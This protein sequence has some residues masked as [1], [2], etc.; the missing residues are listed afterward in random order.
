VRRRIRHRW[1]LR[2]WMQ[3]V[4]LSIAFETQKHKMAPSTTLPI[5][6]KSGNRNDNEYTSNV[7]DIHP[8]YDFFEMNHPAEM[9]YRNDRNG[10]RSYW[11][12]SSHQPMTQDTLTDGAKLHNTE[13]TTTAEVKGDALGSGVAKEQDTSEESMTMQP[14]WPPRQEHESHPE[15][16]SS[17]SSMADI[18]EVLARV[19]SITDAMKEYT[20]KI[21]EQDLHHF[22]RETNSI[23]AQYY[24]C[25]DSQM[26]ETNRLA[27]MGPR[28]QTACDQMLGNY[29]NRTDNSYSAKHLR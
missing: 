26:N 17:L 19:N 14:L 5:A 7:K 18:E 10:N 2:V 23:Q 27:Q 4:N 13:E 8:T 11:E 9:N 28:V 20:R 25:R 3:L 22:L 21:V 29:S 15:C 1:A 24:T 12:S 6:L 16:F